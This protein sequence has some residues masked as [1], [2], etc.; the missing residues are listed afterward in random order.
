MFVALGGRRV[1]VDAIRQRRRRATERATTA[2]YVAPDGDGANERAK[3]P[4]QQQQAGD[5]QYNV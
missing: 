5:V 4:Q 3:Q 1:L 2:H